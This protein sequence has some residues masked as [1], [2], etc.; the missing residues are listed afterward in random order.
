[1]DAKPADHIVDPGLGLGVVFPTPRDIMYR[2]MRRHKGFLSGSTMVLMVV[3][4]ALFASAIAPHDPYQQDLG[5]RMIPPVWA[6][7]GTWEHPLGTDNL[8]R[9]YVSRL[10]YGARVSLLIGFSCVIIASFIGSFLGLMA[11]YYGG[12]VDMVVSFLIT[13]RLALP[14]VL[15]AVAVVALIG[16]SMQIVI[17]TLGCLIWDRFAVVLRATTQQIRSMDYVP[18]AR[19]AGCH[20]ITNFIRPPA[21]IGSYVREWKQEYINSGEHGGIF[22]IRQKAEFNDSFRVIK[23]CL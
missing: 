22:V 11:G 17:I 15:V 2:R 14:A 8:G 4:M 12:K 16:G 13:V 3:L 10:V 21:L 5:K 20:V 9:D 7:K 23:G 18:A 6:E 19:A 1:M